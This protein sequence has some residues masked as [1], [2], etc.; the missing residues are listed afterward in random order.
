[1]INWVMQYESEDKL[2]F[3]LDLF[4]H[5]QYSEQW[6]INKENYAC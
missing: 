2:S 1:M 6:Q 3:S 4:K 5:V